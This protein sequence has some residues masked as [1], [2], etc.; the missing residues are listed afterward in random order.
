MFGL[1]TPALV[2]PPLNKIQPHLGPSM[3]ATWVDDAGW[4][5]RRVTP[6]PGADVFGGEQALA[7]AAAPVA[8]A[9]AVPAAARARAQAQAA[10]SMNNMRQIGL[11][12]IMYANDNNGDLPP[13]LGATTKYI[14]EP[15]V[16]VA[17]EN[18]GKMMR[19]A[20]VKPEELA[21]W[22]NEHADYVY[23]GNDLKKLS[24]V[25][26]PA[27]AIVAYEKPER[28]RNGN[29]A[30]VFA[31]GH[32]EIQPLTLVKDRVAQQKAAGGK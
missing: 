3:S 24:K 1:Q 22:V 26:Q 32:V 8:A 6:F 14:T 11:G 7:K 25:P 12:V 4:H 10:Q 18:R 17:P 27:Q 20:N 21:K 13:D 19:P 9:I 29:L 28:A 2:L 5:Y 16:F 31:D 23:V 30:V 15:M